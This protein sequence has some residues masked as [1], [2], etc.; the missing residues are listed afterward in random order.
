[1]DD[2]QHLRDERQALILIG[3]PGVEADP[4]DQVDAE[5][6]EGPRHQ[7][8]NR[9]DWQALGYTEDP[10]VEHPDVAEQKGHS[11]EVE[12]FECR[13]EPRNASP[14]RDAERSVVEQTRVMHYQAD[15]P[16]CRWTLAAKGRIHED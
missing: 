3:I 7:S 15:D 5:A 4:G 13:P 10:Q 9:P 6:N 12:R 16:L 2:E 11:N 14:D 1:K 8:L